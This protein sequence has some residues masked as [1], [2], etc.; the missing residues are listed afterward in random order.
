MVIKKIKE[1][2]EKIRQRIANEN[3][4]SLYPMFVAT[5]NLIKQKIKK[6]LIRI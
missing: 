4:E 6:L 1:A 3:D 2:I 5:R